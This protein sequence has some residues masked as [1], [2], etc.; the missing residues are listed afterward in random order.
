MGFFYAQ[1]FVIHLLSG[2]QSILFECDNIKE[3][4]IKPFD[5]LRTKGKLLIPIVVSLFNYGRNQ[6]SELP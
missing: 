4:L 3:T 2:Q 5:K 1:R 6:V